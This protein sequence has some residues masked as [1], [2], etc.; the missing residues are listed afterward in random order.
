MLKWVKNSQSKCRNVENSMPKKSI[1][2]IATKMYIY[3][4]YITTRTCTH[5]YFDE[6]MT[7]DRRGHS[8]TIIVAC[9]LSVRPPTNGDPPVSSHDPSNSITWSTK[10]I[11][12]LSYFAQSYHGNCARQ[13][14]IFWYELYLFVLMWN[15]W[16]TIMYDFKSDFPS[17]I[18]L[19]S[20]FASEILF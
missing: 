18:F 6:T 1:I 11:L 10:I 20:K 7:V 4:A 14:Y 2:K 16:N 8:D 15:M 17:E 13:V 19:K 5:K 12:G 9:L 3:N